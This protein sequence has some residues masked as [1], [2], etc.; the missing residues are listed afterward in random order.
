LNQIP[1]VNATSGLH[2]IFQNALGSENSIPR[3]AFN[4]PGMPIAAAITY[5]ALIG[6]YSFGIFTAVTYDSIIYPPAPPVITN[7]PYIPS[8]NPPSTDPEP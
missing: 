3:I 8:L 7:F 1:G 6:E 4:V 5:P 2:D